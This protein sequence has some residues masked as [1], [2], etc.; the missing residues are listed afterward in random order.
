M[1]HKLKGYMHNERGLKMKITYLGTA[2]AEGFPAVFCNCEY[3]REAKR[4]GGKN[5]RSR[6]QAIINNDLLIDL[7]AD[8][9]SHFLNNNIDGDAIKYLLV[10]H[11]HSDHFYERELEMRQG[12]FAHNMRAERLKIYCGMG[13]AEILKRTEGI[14]GFAVDFEALK[15]FDVADMGNY[16]VTALPARHFPG[17][18]ALIYIIKDE[19]TVLYAHDTG[20]FYE[21]V[22]EY[23]KTGGYV[24]DLISLDCTNV[25]IPISDE[26][27]HMGI[28]NINRVVKRLEDM[29][30]VTDK[31]KKVINHFSHNGAPIHHKLE[32]RVKDYGYIVS[33]DGLSIEI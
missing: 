9:Y 3:C 27:T 13:A 33:Y 8:T 7:P 25:D 21:E 28:D 18:G 12:V 29:G 11:S 26:G 2:A 17:D 20:Y 30:A 22:F 10:T 16:T 1:L 32:E 14:E 15:P 6:S 19:K 31:T 5:V 24:F 4:I 23:I